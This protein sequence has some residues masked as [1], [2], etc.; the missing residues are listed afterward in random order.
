MATLK[1]VVRYL[2]DD[3]TAKV[4]IRIGHKTKMAYI[5]SGLYVIKNDL[6]VGA[7]DLNN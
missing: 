1:P 4:E 6:A 2:K 7:L 3:D 5:D